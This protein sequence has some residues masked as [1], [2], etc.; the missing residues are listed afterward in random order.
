MDT[1]DEKCQWWL[2]T[3]LAISLHMSKLTQYSTSRH[4]LQAL[5]RPR[6]SHNFFSLIPHNI[7]TPVH[8]H[9]LRRVASYH[10]MPMLVLCFF[11]RCWVC[12]NRKIYCYI[13]PRVKSHGHFKLAVAM[14]TKGSIIC[15]CEGYMVVIRI[16]VSDMW[17]NCMGEEGGNGRGKAEENCCS[18]AKVN[19][20]VACL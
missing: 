1:P 14:A 13:C 9:F 8:L 2:H 3:W 7:Y 15:E 17:I 10:L 11:G 20:K 5:S 18:M 4:T 6:P 12:V 19:V 16:Y